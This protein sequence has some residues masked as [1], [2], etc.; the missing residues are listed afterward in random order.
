MQNNT[1]EVNVN[2]Q[3]ST[4]KLNQGCLKNAGLR[5]LNQRIF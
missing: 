3:Q 2:L 1:I 4:L 5:N